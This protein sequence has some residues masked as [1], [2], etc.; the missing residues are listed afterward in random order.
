[1]IV[2]Q[3]DLFDLQRFVSAQ[4]PIYKNVLFELGAGCKRTHWMWFVFPQIKGLGYSDL[5]VR[6]A[7][8]GREEAGRYLQHQVLG[9]RLT[10][11]TLILLGSERSASEIFGPPDD[12][13]FQSSMTLFDAVAPNTIFGQTLDKFF[14]GR[15]DQTTLTT[16]RTS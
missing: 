9:S 1:M 7:I 12:R 10:Q 15:V 13:K 2:M 14:E 16:L 3:D 4:D 6:Y 11:C 8:S 5:A